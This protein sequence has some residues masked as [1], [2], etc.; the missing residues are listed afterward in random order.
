M[1]GSKSNKAKNLFKF[2]KSFYVYLTNFVQ[3]TCNLKRAQ[4]ESQIDIASPRSFILPSARRTFIF[5]T[6]L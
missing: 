3:R 6:L 1:F 2:N 5:N 4:Y